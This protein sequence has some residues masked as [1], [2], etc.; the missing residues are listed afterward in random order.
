MYSIVRL[1]RSS[2]TKTKYAQKLISLTSWTSSYATI[3][4]SSNVTSFDKGIR[5]LQ[6]NQRYI[7]S[8]V[9]VNI[10]M[11]KVDMIK[12]MFNENKNHM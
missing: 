5:Y 3:P 10:F 8:S 6:E 9:K 12:N 1:I 4:T 7:P 11:V 2:S